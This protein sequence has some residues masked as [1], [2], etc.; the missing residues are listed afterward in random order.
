MVIV[1]VVVIMVVMMVMRLAENQRTHQIDHQA[2]DGAFRIA[3]LQPKDQ[4]HEE[5]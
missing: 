4:R 1:S 2:A 3:A 5:P